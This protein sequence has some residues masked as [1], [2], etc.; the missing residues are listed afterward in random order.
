MSVG[1]IEH[2]V[3]V[4]KIAGEDVRFI[5]SAKLVECSACLL[6]AVKQTHLVERDE[7][8]TGR[9]SDDVEHKF[10]S[11][12]AFVALQRALQQWQYASR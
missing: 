10:P 5:K 2:D 11:D 7:R 4:R 12:N 1:Y 6:G 3:E 9:F 8:D